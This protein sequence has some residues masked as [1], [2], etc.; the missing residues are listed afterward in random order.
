MSRHDGGEI[1][2]ELLQ[3]LESL[4]IL[5]QVGEIEITEFLFQNTVPIKDFLLREKHEDTIRRVRGTRINRLHS[6]ALQFEV[7]GKRLSGKTSGRV[8]NSALLFARSA[9]FR[10][11]AS[12]TNHS[13]VWSR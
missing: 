9:P 1:E 5:A 3:S 10:P 13:S 11:S 6:A 2:M 4:R 8:D 12:S 7:T